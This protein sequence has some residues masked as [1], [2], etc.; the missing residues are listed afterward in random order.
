MAFTR[1]AV[2]SRLAPPTF[3]ATRASARQAAHPGGFFYSRDDAALLT[4][5]PRHCMMPE[6]PREETQC[7]ARS[8]SR[9]ISPSRRRSA[10]RRCSA[11]MCGKTS[12]RACSTSKTCG[13]REMDK[14][15]IEMMILS[16][17]AP[18]VQ[19]IH[20]VKRAIAVAKQANDMLAEEVRKRPDRFAAF[21][22]LPMQDPEAATAELTRCVKELGFVGALVNGFSQIGNAGQRDLLRSAAIPAVL[23][24]G[25]SARRAVLSASAQSAAELDQAIRRP[26]LAARAELGVFGGN[27]GAR[28]APDRQRPVRRA[29]EAENGARPSRRGHPGAALAHRRPQRL[30]EG[31]AQIRRQARRRPLFP[32]ALSISPRRAIS[33]RRRWSMP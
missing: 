4:A 18:A 9:N 8:R 19:A 5:S 20:D 23:A 13:S 6:K 15:G 24:R 3:A 7:K 25:R 17:N 33:T 21:A 32:Q 31:A 30:D 11:R 16:L 22:A 10:I 29:S 12:A 26:F 14:H 27:R 28:A 2:R 1:S